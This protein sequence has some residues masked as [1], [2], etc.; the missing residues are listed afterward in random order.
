MAEQCSSEIEGDASKASIVHYSIVCKP[1]EAKEKGDSLTEEEEKKKGR[2]Y[3]ADS[4]GIWPLKSP[5]KW[6]LLSVS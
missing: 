4:H 3:S 1:V 6:S 5:S 2:I